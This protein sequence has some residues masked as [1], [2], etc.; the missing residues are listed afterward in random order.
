MYKLR[1]ITL[2]SFVSRHSSGIYNFLTIITFIYFIAVNVVN[3][4]NPILDRNGFRQTQTA[5]VSY[6]QIE[7]GFRLDYLLPVVG[8]PWSVPFEFPIYQTIV[9]FLTVQG[10]IDLDFTGKLTSLL[11]ALATIPYLSRI[12][13]RLFND[14]DTTNVI[15]VSYLT[16]PTIVF[17]SGTFMIEAAALFF[18]I[19]A[20]YH[21]YLAASDER[22]YWNASLFFLLLTLAFLQKVTTI[23]VPFLLCGA[24]YLYFY[25]RN[26]IHLGFWK[27]SFLLAISLLSFT[28]FLFWMKF[29]DGV[30]IGGE[31]SGF[32]TSEALRSWNYGSLD[33]F[34]TPEYI[35][36]IILRATAMNTGVFLGAGVILYMI[37]KDRLI[38][39]LPIA[40]CAT[41]YV[42]P[43]LVFKP[44]HMVHDYYQYA[45]LIY[46][47][48]IIGYFLNHQLKK[49]SR[50]AA[51]FAAVFLVSVNVAV[52]FFVYGSYKFK[53]IDINNN[54]IL[55]ISEYI[56]QNSSNDDVI[57]GLGSDWSSEIP[58]YSRRWA[59][60]IPDWYFDKTSQS[61]DG[62]LR[63][64]LDKW[65]SFS[66]RDLGVIVACGSQFEERA[67]SILPSTFSEKKFSTCTVFV[68]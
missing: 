24:L 68:N 38:L 6:W 1:Y 39:S 58:Y 7:A 59:V 23:A 35:K 9:S 41:L 37:I 47:A 56:K 66:D 54:E 26:C 17:W 55:G 50:N 48:V 22:F 65:P 49:I 45:N 31:I 13:K 21:F 30:K 34:A 32:L 19:S 8:K 43:M 4:S 33:E 51:I 62:G 57:L 10:G 64:I 60:M 67:S 53:N 52:F 15:I 28:T 18:T 12:S 11:F 20:L 40:C 46:L 5:M 63:K 61:V 29:S 3:L 2:T 44:L 36:A 27:F 14:D 25:F 16:M 42:L